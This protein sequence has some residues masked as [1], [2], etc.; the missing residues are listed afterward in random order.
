MTPWNSEAREGIVQQVRNGVTLSVYQKRP[1]HLVA[2]LQNSA[3]R[4]PA[5]TALIEDGRQISYAQLARQASVWA[6]RFTYEYGIRKGDRVALLM[7]NTAGFCLA[8]FAVLQAGGI[9]MP[10]NTKLTHSELE[11]LIRQA[12]PALLIADDELI[13]KATVL[14]VAH[15]LAESRLFADRDA[16]PGEPRTLVEIDEHDPAFLLFTSGTTGLPKGAVISHFNVIHA[17]MTYERCYGLTEQD[18]TIIAVPIFHGTGLFAQLMPFVYLGGSVVLLKTFDAKR[19]LEL[20]E[21]HGVT[22]T[23]V[24]PTIYQMLLALPERR[25]YRLRLRILGSGGAPMFEGM[26]ARLGE[27]LPHARVINTYGLTEATSPAIIMPALQEERNGAAIGIP[28]P[29]MEARIVDPDT[30]DDVRGKQPGELWLKGPLIIER[31]WNNEE[32][33]KAAL[34]DGWLKTGDI[35]VMDEDGFIAVKDRLKDV[36]NRGGE[37]IYSVE[38]ENVLHTHPQ[39]REAAIVGI[40]D[41]RYGEAVMAFVVPES[42]A[43]LTAGD[44]LE[45][46]NRFLATYKVP[47][48][49]QFLEALPRNAGGKVL[50]K[51]LKEE[52]KRR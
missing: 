15:V 44:V 36:I 24:V 43:G 41:E 52:R 51:Q 8:A 9:V 50:K 30:G 42:G 26:P 12:A 4:F 19:M 5:K 29:V 17:C 33:T 20:S 21:Q 1:P 45:W 27:W 37:K 11:V 38:V 7:K 23:I 48:H 6:S 35:A 46:A 3:A 34:R 22:H 14:P 25:H 10:L 28:T 32:A 39:I 13:D 18:S 2:V 49:V 47:L 40:A 31:Y 16:D